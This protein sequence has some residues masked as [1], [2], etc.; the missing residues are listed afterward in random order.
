M[1]IF[2]RPCKQAR[3]ALLP[4]QRFVSFAS[5]QCD[6][7]LAQKVANFFNKDA[8]K[9]HTADFHRKIDNMQKDTK[10]RKYFGY[11]WMKIYQQDISKMAQSGLT[12]P[13]ATVKWEWNF[14]ALLP[15]FNFSFFQ[16]LSVCLSWYPM[17][18]LLFLFSFLSTHCWCD[19]PFTTYVYL[20]L[21]G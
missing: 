1:R 20:Y 12:A 6:Q 16:S 13:C 11:F 15:S 5:V 21:L 9:V 7:M 4:I 19:C 14:L 8:Q 18:I 2:R 10:G 3:K 17:C